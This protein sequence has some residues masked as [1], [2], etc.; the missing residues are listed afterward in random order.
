M[1]ET[2]QRD[3]RRG[4]LMGAA[5]LDDWKAEG[6]GRVD[7]SAASWIS[8]IESNEEPKYCW[9]WVQPYLDTETDVDEYRGQQAGKT[10][11]AEFAKGRDLRAS[12]SWMNAAKK[13]AEKTNE[14]WLFLDPILEADGWKKTTTQEGKPAWTK[15]S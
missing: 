7:K 10:L 1:T 14:Q 9:I 6:R 8:A 3:A 5:W 15:A 11:L 12:Q 4:Q 2:E 13:E